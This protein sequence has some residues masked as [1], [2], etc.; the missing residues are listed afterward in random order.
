M[1]GNYVWILAILA[2]VL[3]GFLLAWAGSDGSM[4]IYGLPLFSISVVFAFLIQW[5]C[6]VPS[7]LFQTEKYFDLMGSLTYVSIIIFAL[8]MSDDLGARKLTIGI[9]VL[10]WAFRLGTFLF[11]RIRSAGED[12]RFKVIKTNFFQFL[13]TWSLQGLWV[14]VTCG[15]ALAA[16]TSDKQNSLGVFFFVGSAFW[17]VGFFVE[18]LADHQKSE[19]N[20]EPENSGKFIHTGLWAWSRHPNYFGEIMLWSGLAVVA[21]PVL[22]GWQHVTLISPIFVFLLLTKISGINLLERQAESR[23]GG[24]PDYQSY[25]R[26]TNVLI[27]WPFR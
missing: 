10:L 12:S 27:I 26:S 22:E 11:S 17:L 1:S 16:I 24:D 9:F 5:I 13:M 21:L 19:F 23:W 6:F 18:V 25:K 14:C 3:F 15:A 4:Q 8:V 2:S 20:R 7:F